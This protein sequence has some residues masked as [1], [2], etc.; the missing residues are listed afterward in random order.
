MNENTTNLT[1]LTNLELKLTFKEKN[2]LIKK[3]QGECPV[4]YENVA[5]FEPECLHRICNECAIKVKQCVI[6]K[7]PFDT[8]EENS[9]EDSEENSEEDSEEDLRYELR[10][11]LIY[12]NLEEVKWFHN[13]MPD[14]FD[15][16][17][18]DLAAKSGHL[19]VVKWLH[20]NTFWRCTTDAMD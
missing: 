2:E 6:C 1:N 14:L 3:L 19:Q 7:E 4:C 10:I 13:N 15:K 11:A 16:D 18:I 17:C 9:E 20:F 8:K 5:N 12:G